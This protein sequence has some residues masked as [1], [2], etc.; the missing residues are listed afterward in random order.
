MQLDSETEAATSRLMRYVG[1][2]QWTLSC[3]PGRTVPNETAQAAVRAAQA[4]SQTPEPDD[5]A[6][7]VIRSGAEALGLTL[8]E[9]AQ[10]LSFDPAKVPAA[11]VAPSPPN[12]PARRRLRGI[13]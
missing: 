3:L 9:F 11:M 12:T 7:N 2:G 1:Q 8:L 6:W 13:R 5:T 4:L 10:C